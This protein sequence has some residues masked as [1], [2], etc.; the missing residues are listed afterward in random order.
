MT[1][2]KQFANQYYHIK[3]YKETTS[4]KGLSIFVNDA[5]NGEVYAWIANHHK[6]TETIP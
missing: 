2:G 6:K 5:C 1:E 4:I 3:N